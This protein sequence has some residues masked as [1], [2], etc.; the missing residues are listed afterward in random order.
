MVE[1]DVV[2]PNGKKWKIFADYSHVYVTGVVIPP[3]QLEG[4][5]NEEIGAAVRSLEH[6]ARFA[7]AKAAVY[8]LI[9]RN[10]AEYHKGGGPHHLLDLVA[11]YLPIVEPFKDQDSKIGHA[12]HILLELEEYAQRRLNPPPR[13]SRRK[14]KKS[15]GELEPP[16]HIM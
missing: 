11:K 14:A 13:R 10:G 1:K 16:T 3:D 15:D 8:E 2:L 12:Y 6:D 9:D 7:M 5:S 4:M